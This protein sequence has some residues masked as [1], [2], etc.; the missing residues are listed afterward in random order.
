MCLRQL[1]LNGLPDWDMFKTA[2]VDYAS[3]HAAGRCISGGPIYIT[4]SPGQHN[5]N[6]IKLMT[7]VTTQY[8][9]VTLRPSKVALPVDPFVVFNQNRLLKVSNFCGDHGG[10]ALLAVF[11]VSQTENTEFVHMQDFRGI[12]QHVNYIARSHKSGRVFTAGKQVQKFLLILTLAQRDWDFFTAI[13]VN[14]IQLPF[15]KAVVE[16]GTFGLISALTGVAA[17]LHNSV[18]FLNGRVVLNVTLKALGLLG[19][20]KLATPLNLCSPSDS[21]L[22]I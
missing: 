10:S 1:D 6:V 14:K 13:P 4:D 5:K 21:L 15:R 17:I 9:T 2:L 16:V 3:F 11:N 19:K 8:Q 22:Y 18:E 12:D 20:V 7:A